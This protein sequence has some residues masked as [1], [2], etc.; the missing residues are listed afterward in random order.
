MRFI[1]LHAYSDFRLRTL[2]ACVGITLVLSQQPES[3]SLFRKD[4]LLN[5]LDSNGDTDNLFLDDNSDSA[6]SSGLFSI[7]PELEP[8]VGDSSITSALTDQ[9]LLADTSN[10]ECSIKYSLP[11]LSRSRSRNKLRARS[12]L[13]SNSCKDPN[14]VTTGKV[15]NSQEAMMTAEEIKKHWCGASKVPFEGFG[16]VPVCQ[17]DCR[18]FEGV[19]SELFLSNKR[20]TTAFETLFTCNLSKIQDFEPRTLGS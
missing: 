1:H 11:P 7:Q 19:P 6:G 9:L 2:W 4:L 12:D 18:G 20:P 5:E 14:V 13:D 16:N 8:I 10:D 15:E 17:K 3:F